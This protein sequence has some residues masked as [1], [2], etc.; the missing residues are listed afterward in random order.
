[1]RRAKFKHHDRDDDGENSVAECFQPNL[2]QRLFP[3]GDLR[4]RYRLRAKCTITDRNRAR[5]GLLK[6]SVAKDWA[7]SSIALFPVG[8]RAIEY[9]VTRVQEVQPELVILS[10]TPIRV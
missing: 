5:R 7:V 2:A 6:D 8:A 10:L 3:L 4:G 9:A 1:M